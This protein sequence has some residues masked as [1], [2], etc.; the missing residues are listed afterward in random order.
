MVRPQ[1]AIERVELGPTKPIGELVDRWRQSYSQADGAEFRKLVWEPLEDKLAAAT[2]VLV[3]PDGALDRFPLAALP[4]KK[5]GT[6]L[7]EDVAIATVPIPRLLPELLAAGG[8][9]SAR[10]A[11]NST[12]IGIASGTQAPSLLTVGNV[13]FKAALA[14]NVAADQLALR[15]RLRDGGGWEFKP[16]DGTLAEVLTIDSR[17]E[18]RFPDGKHKSLRTGAATKQAVCEAMPQYSYLHLATHGFFAPPELK[19]A[20]PRV[21][22]RT[23]AVRKRQNRKGAPVH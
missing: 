13:D 12:N 4:G 11:E 14:T 20:L 19:S 15:A 21:N 2:T 5:D 18:D 9:G 23:Q 8:T 10:A 6:Y 1:Q 3:S 22:R 16:L 17:F 7:I